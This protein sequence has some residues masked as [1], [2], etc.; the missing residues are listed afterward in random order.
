M[1][2]IP[3]LVLARLGADDAAVY[4][5]VWTIVIALYLVP[6]GMGQSMIAHTAGDP[7]RVDAA[8]WA[9]VR[10]SLRLVVPAAGVLA[11]GAYPVLRLFGEHYAQRGAWT[12]ALAA[13]SAIPQVVT[14]ATVAAARVQQRRWVLVAVP[15]SIAVAVL[16]GAWLLT[17]AL[18]IAGAALSWLVVQSVAAAVLLARTRRPAS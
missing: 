14:A 12:L 9:M 1:N 7:G 8:R 3:A 18:G 16:A 2:A 15:G 17:P 10:R 4:G 11:V 6:S 13:L 5:I